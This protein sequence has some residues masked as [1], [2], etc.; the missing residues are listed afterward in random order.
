MIIPVDDPDAIARA[1]DEAV[2]LPFEDVRHRADLGWAHAL[3][4]DRANVFDRMFARVFAERVPATLRLAGIAFLLS[5]LVGV[6]VGVVAALNRNTLLDR[7]VMSLS[8]LGQ[9]LPNFILGIALIL[10]FSLLLRV[11]PSGA[12][13]SP[14]GSGESADS[15]RVAAVAVA[16][17]GIARRRRVRVA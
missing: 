11:L 17:S 7:A 1:I 4:F 14:F 2:A 12:A 9:A 10:V 8:F 13:R 5:L 15:R 16:L 3:Q 6:P